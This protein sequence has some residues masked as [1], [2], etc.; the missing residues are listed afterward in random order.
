MRRSHPTGNR[1]FTWSPSS[2]APRTRRTA[3]SG[4]WRLPEAHPKRLTTAPGSNNHPRWSPD[5]KTIAFASSRGGS[6]QVWL[7]PLAGGE[8]QQLTKLPIDVSGPL[9]SPLGDK[10][11]FVAEVIPGCTPEETAA[12]DKERE[13]AKSKVRIFDHLMIRH[14]TSWDE[15]KRSHLFVA[16]AKSGQARDLTPKLEVNTPP[17]PFGGSTDYAWS[18]DGKELAFTAEPVKNHAWSTNNDIWTVPAEGGD[19]KNVTESNAGADAQ[20]AY[21]PDGKFLAYVSQARAG[22]ESDLWVL[23]GAQSGKRRDLDVSSYLGSSSAVVR[24]AKREVA[25]RRDRRR[26]NRADR[27]LPLARCRRVARPDDRSGW[28]RE[29]PVR[30]SRSDPRRRPWR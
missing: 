23:Q 14:W 4:S 27:Q 12:K 18:P 30:G 6:S 11:A 7:L 3:A 17:A 26:G 2:T 22:F 19:P 21:S 1:W 8:A 24:L 15:R 25:G 9:W 5:G 16:D 20:P 28:S 10:I 13:A 29:G